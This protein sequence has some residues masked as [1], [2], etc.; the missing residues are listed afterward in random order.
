MPEF[1]ESR[2]LLSSRDLVP[3]EASVLVLVEV[4]KTGK[5][6]QLLLIG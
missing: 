4:R 3:I 5:I 6:C 2:Y 1:K